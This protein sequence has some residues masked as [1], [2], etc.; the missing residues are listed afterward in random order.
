MLYY[1]DGFWKAYRDDSY[2]GKPFPNEIE[3]SWPKAFVYAVREFTSSVI[4]DRAP[5][6]TGEEGRRAIQLI[7]AAY[8]SDRSK[9][10]V[11]V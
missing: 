11:S 1:H 8:E 5:R 7:E 10:V 4:E 9:R 3:W 6:V 2:E